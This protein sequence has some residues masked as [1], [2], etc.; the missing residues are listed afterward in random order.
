MKLKYTTKRIELEKELNALDAFVI[1]FTT[2]LNRLNINYV[3]VSGYVSILFG[4]NRTSEDIDLILE[5]MNLEKFKSLWNELSKEFECIITDNVN[6]AYKD[7]L[8]MNNAIRFSRKENFIPNIEIKFPKS[9]LD[10]WTLSNKKEVLLNNHLLFISP[11]ELQIPF[12]L[13]L[14]SE[15][16]IEDAKYLY[17]IFKSHL[18]M[19]SLSKFNR[20]LN[21]EGLFNRY[22]K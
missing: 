21:I 11:F 5:K 22:L 1:D 16:D 10:T 14:G 20:K 13:V 19:H 3:I 12:K 8:N 4:R 9:E 2:I 15:K 6:L 17:N 18:N 7:Y